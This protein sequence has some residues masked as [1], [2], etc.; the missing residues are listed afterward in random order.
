MV[1]CSRAASLSSSPWPGTEDCGRIAG[2]GVQWQILAELLGAVP[3]LG[4]R[5]WSGGLG[6][7]GSVLVQRPRGKGLDAGVEGSAQG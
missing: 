7:E 3:G 6:A 5:H 2:S 4:A 1:G